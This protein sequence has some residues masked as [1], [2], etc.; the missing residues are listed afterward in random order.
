MNRGPIRNGQMSPAINAAKGYYHLSLQRHGTLGNP[1]LE[2]LLEDL[3]RNSMILALP[4]LVGQLFLFATS[5]VF[6]W[7]DHSFNSIY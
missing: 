4:Y 6:D 2:I 5:S 1:L 7:L 3:N